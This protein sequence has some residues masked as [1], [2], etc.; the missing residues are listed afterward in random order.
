MNLY[1]K[2]WNEQVIRKVF[3]VDIADKILHTPLIHQVEE[4]RIIWKEE[5]NDRYSVSSAYRLCVTELIDSSCNWRPGY[6]SG[7]RKLKV[8][9]KVKNIVWRLCRGCLP[10]RVSLLDKGVVCPTNCANCDSNNED[11]MHVF[12]IVLLQFRFGT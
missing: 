2:S 6:W 9:P 1:D 11:L 10:M 7:I 3:S 4:D 5:R 8:P 12:F